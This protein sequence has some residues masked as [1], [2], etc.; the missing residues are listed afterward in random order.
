MPMLTAMPSCV[1]SEIESRLDLVQDLIEDHFLLTDL[2][3]R[4]SGLSEIDYERLLQR[5]NLGQAS[6]ADL[7]ALLRVLEIIASISSRLGSTRLG[8]NLT[9][10]PRLAKNIANVLDPSKQLFDSKEFE[11]EGGLEEDEERDA[12]SMPKWN[13]Q[14]E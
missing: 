12:F 11:D 14:P 3:D 10:A 1:L 13:V 6:V 5:I 8:K 7:S 2:Q 9:A 4:L